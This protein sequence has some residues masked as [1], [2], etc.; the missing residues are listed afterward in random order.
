MK[1][2]FGDCNGRGLRNELRV[3]RGVEKVLRHVDARSGRSGVEMS[4][5]A[6]GNLEE[7]GTGKLGSRA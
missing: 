6:C 5:I 4:S 7:V 2:P 3:L 1:V